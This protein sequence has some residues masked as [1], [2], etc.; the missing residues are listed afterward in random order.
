MRVWGMVFAGLLAVGAVS[1]AAEHVDKPRTASP[2][3]ERA[4]AYLD[5]LLEQHH[6]GSQELRALVGGGGMQV[7][8]N[9]IRADGARGRV[10]RN[11]FAGHLA[12]DLDRPMLVDWAKG[13]LSA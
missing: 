5:S 8:A 12:T 2:R 9:P 7:L 10:R 3:T 11:G 4:I 6:I 13:K 1:A